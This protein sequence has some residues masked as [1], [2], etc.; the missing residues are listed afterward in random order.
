MRIPLV[1]A[2]CLLASTAHAATLVGVARIPADALD[3]QGETLGGFGSGMTLAPGSW[4]RKGKVFVARIDFLPDRGWNTAGTVDYRARVQRFDLSLLPDDGAPGHEGQLKLTYKKSLLLTDAAGVPTTG[5][6]PAFVRP[7]ANGFPD[8]PV[9]A[10]GHVSLDNEAIAADGKGGFWISDEYG[11][12]VYHYDARGRM[13]GAIRPP[14]AFIPRR[15]GKEDFS[16]N[17]P[18]MGE[19][20]DK[21]DPQTGRQNNQGFEGL[22]LSHDRHTLFVVNQSA[23]RQ[24]L[25]ANNAKATRRHVRLLAYD[26]QGMPRL[27]HEYVIALPIYQEKDK[28]GVAAQSELLAIDG[29]RFALLCRDSNGG[30]TGKRDQSLYRKVELVDIAGATDIAGRYDDAAGSVAPNGVLRSE[31]APAQMSDLVD[32]NDNTQLARFGLHNGAPN[33]SHDLYEKWESLALAPAEKPGESILLVGSDND[34]I[35]QHGQMAG[36]SYA[37]DTNADVDTLVMAWRV[38]LSQ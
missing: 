35:T 8:L 29:H 36:K 10:N 2:A 9:A 38:Q 1:L 27:I 33:D 23:L 19:H 6:D 12:Y 24:D 18:P 11:P 7:S 15:D 14:E 22:S 28:V 5:L 34:F 4:H 17:S 13:I 31:I 3:A 32:L 21:G 20:Y 25:D 30:F 16:A 37:D 26:I